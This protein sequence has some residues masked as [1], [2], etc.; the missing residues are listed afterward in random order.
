MVPISEYKGLPKC[1]DVDQTG[2]SQEFQNYH[3][4]RDDF[5][6]VMSDWGHGTVWKF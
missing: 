2:S 5:L 4:R 3:K 6:S 1:L